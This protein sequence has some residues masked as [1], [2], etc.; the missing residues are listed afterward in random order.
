MAMGVHTNAIAG[1]P[2]GAALTRDQLYFSSVY[3]NYA[4]S[5]LPNAADTV[6]CSAPNYCGIRKFIDPLPSLP[7]ANADTT[8][9]PGSDYYEIS[10]RQYTQKM[11]SDLLPT[12][13]RGYVQTNGVAPAPIQYLGPLI[14]AQR[15]RAVRIKFTN[16]LPTGTTPGAIGPTN[17]NL[18]IPT[19]KTVL[20]SGL[21]FALGSSPYLENRATIH[22]HGGNTPWISDGTPHQW[23]VPAGNFTDSST[24]YTR[25]ASAEFVPDMFFVGGVVVPQCT[26]TVTTNCSGGTA[27]QMPAGASN[28]S[29][30]G[31]LTFYYTNQ[32]SARLMFYHDHAYGTTRLNVYAGEAAGYLIQDQIEADMVNGTN[33][34]GVFTAAGI[35]PTPV[36]PAVQIPLVIQ[37]KTFVPPNPVGG[38]TVY[39][40]PIL[41]NGSGYSLT[42]TVAFGAG[43][44]TA[45]VA[46]ATSGLLI[47]PWGQPIQGAITG[48]TLTSPGAGCT[49]DPSVTIT[50]TTGIGAAAFASLATLSQQ[51]PTWDTTLWGGAGSL[52]YPHVYMPNQWPGNPD[53]SAVNPMGRWDYASWFWPVFTGQYQVRGDLACPTAFDT[54][55][56]CP[57]TPSALDPAPA[58][59]LATTPGGAQPHQGVGS[60]ASLTP[61]AFMDTMLVNGAAYPTLTV[62]P[63]AYRFR[64]L[65]AGNDR[66]LNLSWFVACGTAG[67]T[68]SVGAFLCPVPTVAGIVAG[69]E[70]GMVPATPNPLNPLWWPTD[71]RDGGVPD[72]AASGPSWLQ[73]GSEGGFLPGLAV[74]PPAPINYE[75]NRRSVTVT[76][77]SSHSLNLM[78]AERADVIVDFSAFGGKTLILYNDAPAPYPAFDSRYDYYTGDP[79]QS[80][81]GG[82]PTTLA[83]FAPNTRTV[84]QVKV[85]AGAGVPFVST[86]LAL[87][88]PNAFKLGQPVPIVPE[89]AFS[90]IYNPTGPAY[91]NHY[92]HLADTQMTFVP[93]NGTLPIT[94]PMR[95]K[96][97]Q[98]LFELD[99]GRMNSTLGTEL[100]LTNF[101]TQTTIPLGDVDPFTEDIYDSANV[102][103]QPVGSLGDGS[104]VWE[105]IH[106]G[107]DSHAIHFHLYNVQI[108]NRVGWDGTVRAPDANELGWKDTVRMNPLEIDFVA[109]RPMSQTM[110]FPVPDSK[111]LLDVTLPAGATD[112]SLSAF[113]PLNTAVPQTNVEVNLGWEY[114][115]HC[116]ILGHEENDMMR[117]QTF[118]VPPQTP[119]NLAV[120]GTGSGGNVSFTDQSLSETMFRLQRSSAADTTFTTPFDM[121]LPA[122]PGYNVKVVFPDTTATPGTTYNYRVRTEKPDVDYYAPGN[123]LVSPWSNVAATSL[124]P[125][126][127][128]NP[129]SLAFGGNLVNVTSAPK[130]VT[131][132]N[133]GFATL[134]I[135][136]ITLTGA[137]PTYFAQTSPACTSLAHNASCTISVTFTPPVIGAASAAISI[138]SNDPNTPVTVSLTGTGF[139]PVIGITPTAEAFGNQRY[140][141]VSGNGTAIKVSNTGTG[142]LTISSIT[143]TGTNP[144]DFTRTTTCGA[145]LAVGSTCTISVKFGPKAV[146][147]RSAR[148]TISSNDPV[149]PTMNVTLTGPGIAAPVTITAFSTSVS[150]G[151]AVPALTPAIVGLVAPD[152]QANLGALTCSTT[153]TSASAVGTYPSTCSGAVNANYTFTY[154]AGTITVTGQSSTTTITSHTPNPTLLGTAT[155]IGVHVAPQTSGTPTGT[156]VVTSNSGETCTATLAGGNGTCSITFTTAGTKTL[157]ATYGGTATWASSVSPAVTHTVSAATLTVSPTAEAFGNRTVGTTSGNG[158]AITIRNLGVATITINSVLAGAFPGDYSRTT[159]CGAT[160]GA[161]L[162][163]T[164]S[165]RFSP[166]ALGLRPAAVNINTN[167][168]FTPLVTVTL[169]G[170]GI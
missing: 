135:T 68:P 64:I 63:K 80:G 105:V 119:T 33:S 56:V 113:G 10:L 21:G 121:V 32:Q 117:D 156:V 27:A 85:N 70:V 73:I 97:I 140:G 13:L 132:T 74:Y 148:V 123:N 78:P 166:K 46:T 23:T 144:A 88:L 62:D 94:L 83:G 75:Y 36:I 47:N 34:T 90:K 45:P 139:A 116:H 79:D 168:P 142:L 96:T 122:Q 165:V 146:G 87:V 164:I 57:G 65:S 136:G 152:T 51:D 169:T 103:A 129:T 163:C 15:D 22:L 61:E 41:A 76:N 131:L 125:V 162:S 35:A 2:G 157:T 134:T 17:G 147:A 160:L 49:S 42:P 92:L 14:I 28:D 154:V 98:E 110:P 52:W 29:G 84:M 18:F 167:D 38:T 8:T 155:A 48:I 102:S 104:Q 39:S 141:T 6:N 153:Y 150:T 86:N 37:D 30:P 137:N 53:G 59:Y 67:Y 43:C 159:T 112:P 71:G 95:N 138:A 5:P 170:T 118:Q 107:V 72:P 19:D 145:T 7:V 4:N 82:A 101:N 158:T 81:A 99:Y 69:T 109:L 11:S 130:T 120:A 127:S 60:T 3:P 24:V 20:G 58:S 149:N 128:V 161:G 9:F 40:V 44:T 1:Q 31:T 106:N 100:A 133:T 151:S 16:E 54:T 124:V 77:T 26:L 143:V 55:M 126:A 25:G 111:R 114:V 108:I 50:D 66:S 91:T 115:W 89:P 12:T 93:I